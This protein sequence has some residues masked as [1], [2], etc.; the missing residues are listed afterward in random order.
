MGAL[1]NILGTLIEGIFNC[2][3]AGYENNRANIQKEYY[4]LS[5]EEK[6]LWMEK[7]KLRKEEIRKRKENIERAE[8]AYSSSATY[9]AVDDFVDKVRNKL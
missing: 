4:D 5:E 6:T 8:S 3:V 1:G 9:D 2:T 7:D